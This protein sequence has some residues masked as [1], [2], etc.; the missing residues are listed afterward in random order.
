MIDPASPPCPIDE[1]G[2][3][4]SQIPNLAGVYF[5]DADKDIKKILK[6]RGRLVYEGT[7]D[8]NYPF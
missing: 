4:T 8:H 5:K 7:I 2:K 3:F 1:N 6:Q